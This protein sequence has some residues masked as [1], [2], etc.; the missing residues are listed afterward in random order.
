MST[1]RPEATDDY[2]KGNGLGAFGSVLAALGLAGA[3]LAFVATFSTV[4]KIRVLTVTT[5]HYTGMDRNGIACI[6]LGAFALLMI[7]GA[8][9]GA[10]PA[11]LA[12]GLIGLAALLIAILHDL[13]HLNDTG[14][15]PLH[16]QY[17]DAQASAGSGY[18]LETA[19]G[20]LMLVSGV[21]LLLL[22]P[23]GERAPRR[24]RP[25][26]VEQAEVPPNVR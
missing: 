15:W 23:R 14:V 12:L 24:P 17:E 9:R 7:A 11:M 21:G 6:L 4:I 1:H 25:R 20:I 22:A 18:Y 3:I 16:D 2:S 13:P 26:R 10:R 8:V 19:A 5:A